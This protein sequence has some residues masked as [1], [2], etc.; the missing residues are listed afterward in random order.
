MPSDGAF[1]YD[2]TLAVSGGSTYGFMLVT[3][4]G[5]T[6]QLSVE[7]VPG[8]DANRIST[9]DAASHNDFAPQWDTPFAMYDFSGGAGQLEYDGQDE[10]AFWWGTAVTHVAG[11]VFCPPPVTAEALSSGSG[12]I[13]GFRAY[14][15]AGGTAYDFCWQATRLYRRDA[16]N[17]TNDWSLVYTASATI[18]DFQIV[19]GAG[20]IAVPSLAGNTDFLYQGTITAV[21]TWTPTARNH[22]AFSDAL[23]KP[24]FFLTVRGTLYAVVDNRKVF[25]TVD[26]TTDSW[27][28]PI[29]TSLDGNSSGPPGD[30]TYGFVNVAAVLDY[31]MVFKREAGYNVDSQQEVTEVLWQWKDKPSDHNFKY[32]APGG[33]DLFFNIGPEVYGYDPGTGALSD[34]KLSKRSGFSVQEIAGLGADNQ[35][36]YVLA[37]VR[38]PKL[39]SAASMALLRCWRKR[40]RDWGVNCIWE[41]TGSTGYATLGVLPNGVGTRVYWGGNAGGETKLMDIP[42]DWDESSGASFATSAVLYTSISRDNFPGFIKR[43]LWHGSTTEA[44]DANNTIAVAYSL[45]EGAS[46]ATL[47]TLSSAGLATNGFS[48]KQS[49][50]YVG[51]Y[52][53]ACAG[54]ATPIL[55]GFDLHSRVRFRY[56]PTISAGLRVARSVELRNGSRFEAGDE[57][58]IKGY[59]E[60]LRA[61]DAEITYKD[62]LGNSFAV[63]IDRI[64]YRPTRHEEPDSRWEVEALVSMARADVGT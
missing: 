59:L 50:S 13:G 17:A 22:T 31:L 36:V 25:Y 52:T 58:T 60:T 45:D 48:N 28:G 23:G 35:Y 11:K 39:R 33:S 1:P 19:D 32:V 12:T 18:T 24:K 27:V 7:E 16:S 53:F 14:R 21:A 40:G 15:P 47:A 26:G 56:L 6:K 43:R 44:L 62:F 29:D 3:P 55:R 64:A 38:V 61:T 49:R 20:Y 37:K 8:P 9:S 10:T 30:T 54:T 46:F 4:P 34:L 5:S 2:V 41:D 51:R 42:A 57:A 63:S